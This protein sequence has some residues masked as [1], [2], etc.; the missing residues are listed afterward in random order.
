MEMV[1]YGIYSGGA[2][3]Q[4]ALFSKKY[5]PKNASIPSMYRIVPACVSPVTWPFYDFDK[6]VI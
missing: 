5:A 3:K 4:N 1:K 2:S 6:T